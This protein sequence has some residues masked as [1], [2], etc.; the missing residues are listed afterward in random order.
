MPIQASYLSSLVS[1]KKSKRIAIVECKTTGN[2]ACDMYSLGLIYTYY[3]TSLEDNLS[4]GTLRTGINIITNFDFNAPKFF[5]IVFQVTGTIKLASDL[6]NIVKSINFVG[7]QQVNNIIIDLNNNSGLNIYANYCSISG[8]SIINSNNSGINVYNSYTVI[9]KCYICNN[10]ENGIYIA[11]SSA[12][13]M[14]GTNT[15]LNSNYISNIL[16]NNGKNGI[17]MNGSSYNTLHKNYVGTI[18]GTTASPNTNNGIYITNGSS[19]NIIGGKIF[20][21]SAG[22]VNNPTGTEGNDPAVYIIPPQ[23]NLISGNLQNGVLVDLNS[24]NNYFYGNF[25]GTSSTGNSALPNTLNGISF[26]NAPTNSVI[27]C[28]VFNNPFVFYNVISGNNANGIQIKNSNDCVI[29]GNFMGITMNN[30]NLCP[31]QLDGLLV[32][33]TSTDVQDGGVIPLGNVI[34]GN[35]ENGIH[36]TD[37]ASG[38][39]SFNTFAG[40]FAFGG[41]AP[42]NV[43]GILV[44]GNAV[45]TVIRTCVTSGNNESGIELSGNSS[46]TTVEDV[47]CGTQTNSF[48]ALPNK[49]GLTISGNSNNNTVQSR[50]SV[51]FNNVFSGNTNNGIQL[52]GASNTN[53]FYNCNIGVTVFGE[54]ENEIEVPNGNN[55]VF[56][57]GTSSDNIFT[58]I[59]SDI[60]TLYNVISGNDNYGIFFNSATA[61]NNSFTNNYIGVGRLGNPIPNASGNFGGTIDPSNTITPNNT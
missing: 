33:G 48:T 31:N 19:N 60:R 8:I 14:I 42:N 9:E 5:Y 4:S 22:L 13:N 3:V 21:N 59:V 36:V 7:S 26:E 20:K 37:N 27:G 25:I 28:E 45:Q 58:S 35:N 47:I 51:A 57:D 54:N 29:Q 30:Q 55:G 44:D 18:D 32:N 6:Q 24:N 12:S 38:F 39:I 40:I 53:T 49:N 10:A 50:A 16:A 52:L 11:P 2:I 34:A 17:E 46:Y 43:N 23:G 15:S 41:A 61:I 56:L 1:N